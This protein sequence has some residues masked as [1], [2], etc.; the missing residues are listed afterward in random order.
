MATP[1]VGSE[2]QTSL[3]AQRR[4]V[5]SKRDLTV[6]LARVACVL[7]VVVVH[8]LFT[9]VRE[10][11]QGFEIER[12]VELQHWFNAVS[13]VFEIMPLFFVVGGFASLAAYRSTLRKGLDAGDYV[14]GRILRLARPALPLFV[15]FAIALT[16]AS[17]M[18]VDPSLV[19]GIAIGIGSPLWFL[20][21]FI[22]AQA[23]VPFLV[24]WHER[25]RLLTISI[26]MAGALVVDVIRAVTGNDFYGL[27]NVFLVW[28]AIQQ[29][30]FWMFDGWFLQR[31][32]LELV[33]LVV[34]AYLGL[35]ACVGLGDYSLN[36]LSN[37][38]PPTFPL[39][40]LG[41]AQAAAL[42]LL[43]PLLTRLMQLRVMQGIV[44]WVGSRAMTIYCWHLPVIVMLIGVMVALPGS[45]T[46]PGTPQWWLERIPFVC[47]VLGVIGVMSLWLRSFEAAP[48]PLESDEQRPRLWKI[49]TSLF[50]FAMAPF[51]IM[52]FGLDVWLAILGL[53]GTA[54][55]ITLLRPHRELTSALAV[56]A[57]HP[58]YPMP[59]AAFPE[60]G[61]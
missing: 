56:Q 23:L 4:A 26:L 1:D 14:R 46:E 20:S 18:P 55:A 36:M 27:L 10:S 9:G 53:A 45:L 39:I 54:T 32:G 30:G 44:W 47:V 28:P 16:T 31:R 29:I 59:G 40:L 60:R 51:L 7:L 2:A 11:A 37:Q 24:Y 52:V 35:W 13:W 58:G 17:L 57:E 48:P 38:Y 5:L 42:T 49:L 19:D 41:I 6:D 22:L 12:T 8:T 33:A 43:R 25:R 21:S 3:E 50:I 61:L 15:F 34:G